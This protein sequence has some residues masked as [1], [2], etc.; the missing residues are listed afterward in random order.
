[1]GFPG[2]SDGKASA[3]NAGDLG[4]E[5]PLEK[6]K[7]T[8]SSILAWKIPWTEEPGGLQSMGS[9]RVGQLSNFTFTFHFHALEKK[10]HSSVLVWRI[11]GMVEPGGQPSMGSH[12]VRHNWSDLAVTSYIHTYIHIHTYTYIYIYIHIH[13]YIHYSSVRKI[14]WRTVGYPLQ[15]SWASLVTQMVKNLSAR[16]ETWVWFLGWKDP[17]EEGM[18]THS[19]ILAWRILID[20]GAWWD[21]VHKYIIYMWYSPHFDV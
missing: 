9:L 5:D 11:P 13:T 2:G 15:Y 1:M 8:H 19:S 12:R 18:A 7:A 4:R 3:Y 16:W 17:L 21:T 10:R 14:P 20:R 6:E